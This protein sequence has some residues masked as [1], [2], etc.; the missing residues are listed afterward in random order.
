[1][2]GDVR[3]IQQTLKKWEIHVMFQI[4]CCRYVVGVTQA[5][6]V[7]GILGWISMKRGWY[8]RVESR[9]LSTRRQQQPSSKFK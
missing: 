9:V 3:G 4:L 6:G 2:A 7:K 5:W 8:F 1:M